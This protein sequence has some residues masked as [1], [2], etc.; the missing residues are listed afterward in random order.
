MIAEPGV[1]VGLGCVWRVRGARFEER[2]SARW[3][4]VVEFEFAMLWISCE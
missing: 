3:A 2:M 4:G 1:G